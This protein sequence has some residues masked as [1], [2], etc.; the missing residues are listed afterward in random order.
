M[1]SLLMTEKESSGAEGRGQLVVRQK[2]QVGSAG[3]KEEEHLQL[4]E[5]N[6]KMP[7]IKI[8]IEIIISEIIYLYVY[9]S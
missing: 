4:E 2:K 6:I 3:L 7:L 8:I 5:R 1:K 9:V